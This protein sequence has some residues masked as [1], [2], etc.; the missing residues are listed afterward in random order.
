MRLHLGRI[1]VTFGVAIDRSSGSGGTIMANEEAIADAGASPDQP[2][3]HTI[4]PG[5]L[6]DALAK[7]LADFEAMPTHVAFLCFI[8]PILMLIAARVSAGYDVLPLVFPILAGYTL[9]GPVVATGMY[10]LSRRRERGLDISRGQVVHAFDVLRS[11]SIWAIAR[12]SALLLTVYFAWL[13]TAWSIYEQ[14]FGGGAD[15][16]RPESIVEFALQVV[17]TPAGA[18]THSRGLRRWLHLRHRGV[19]PQ[20][21]VLSDAC[22]PGRRRRGGG[23]NV[24][25]SGCREPDNHG[26][27]G[28][29]RRH[30]PVDR[31]LALILGPRRRAAG[32]R[33]RD[34]ASVSQGCGPRRCP[35]LC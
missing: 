32:A 22:G 2:I 6:R 12:L 8:Y 19:R 5:D 18:D 26:D 25:K 3:V 24:N 17:A 23:S 13:M 34:L 20:R 31:F 33:T 21:G 35:S 14:N 27:V 30:R 29:D 10:E 7:G 15:R 16:T 4:G 28:L 1:C 11:P 9:I